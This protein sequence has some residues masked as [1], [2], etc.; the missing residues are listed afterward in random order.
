MHH[1]KM[2]SKLNSNN[3]FLK[4]FV[5]IKN[6]DFYANFEDLNLFEENLYFINF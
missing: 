5:I 3:L 2:D 1:L 4:A 6:H